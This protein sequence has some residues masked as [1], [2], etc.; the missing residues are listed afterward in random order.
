MSTFRSRRIASATRARTGQPRRQATQHGIDDRPLA[1]LGRLQERA[2]RRPHRDAGQRRRCRPKL[3]GWFRR[4]HR[5]GRSP[6]CAHETRGSPCA[7]A[8][9]VNAMRSSNDGATSPRS[10]KSGP[11]SSRLTTTAPCRR[12]ARSP[13]SNA[14]NG[15]SSASSVGCSTMQSV[16]STTSAERD[17]C[18][19]RMIRPPTRRT[20]KIQPPSLT[21]Q[22]SD[23]LERT[24][25]DKPGATQRAVQQA[26][27]PG[28]I[29]R[30]PC[31]VRSTQPPQR[32]KRRHG[33]TARRAERL[34]RFDLQ[35]AA[36]PLPRKAPTVTSSPGNVR[37]Q[38]PARRPTD[39]RHRHRRTDMIDADPARRR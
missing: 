28:A 3:A 15:A 39:S 9:S 25:Q 17:P 27:L 14:R 29:R 21:W 30:V 8:N 11:T 13:C 37:E 36:A 16:R 32:P 22:A 34:D 19:P 7:R 1:R 18:R 38:V 26:G 6:P 4:R 33:G 10:S 24:R 35:R 23:Q 2:R 5:P 20:A 31:R 12:I